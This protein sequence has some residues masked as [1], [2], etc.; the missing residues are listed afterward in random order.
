[1]KQKYFID[2]HKAITPLAILA[3]M[4]FYGQ[5]YNPTAWVYFGLHGSYGL[6]WVLKSRIFGDRQWEQPTGWGYGLVI[7]GGLTLYWLAPWLITSR[8]VEAPPWLLGL[9]VFAYGVGVFLHFAA[10]M[11]KSTALALRPGELITDGLFARTRNPNYLGEL[12]IYLSF[13][14]L[15]LHWAP[16]LVV[17]LFLVVVWIPN[18]RRK[19]R[20][21]ARYPAFADYRSRSGLLI[22]KAIRK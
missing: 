9:C 18:M 7:W 4:A 10:D 20:S 5:W 14:L 21:L 11:Q 8:S 17:A 2:S 6:L 15:A 12:L 3:L 1:V 13:A 16:L 19:D 22:P